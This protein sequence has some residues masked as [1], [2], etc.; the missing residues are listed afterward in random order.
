[1][2]ERGAYRVLVENMKER[3]A[4][5]VLVENMKERDHLEGLGLDWAAESGFGSRQIFFSGFP[6]TA[7]PLKIVTLNRTERLGL[8]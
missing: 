5:R 8:V 1:M 3:G 7:D 6:A 2:K 4:Y